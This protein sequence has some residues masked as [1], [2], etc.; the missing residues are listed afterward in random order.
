MD[1]AI[2]PPETKLPSTTIS[3]PDGRDAVILADRQP[4]GGPPR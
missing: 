2:D 4:G 1:S 3:C